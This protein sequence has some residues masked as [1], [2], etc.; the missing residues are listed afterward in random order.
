LESQVEKLLNKTGISAKLILQSLQLTLNKL[1]A[2]R[3]F[4]PTE[5]FQNCCC[6]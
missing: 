6:C 4:T 1:Y 2:D 5:S 3:N